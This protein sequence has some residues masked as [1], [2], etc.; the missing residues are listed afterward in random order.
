VREARGE[1]GIWQRRYWEH[2]I[3]DDGD[4][5][6]HVDYCYYNPV[7]H[8]LVERVRDWPFSTYHRDVRA[9]RF[10]EDWTLRAS[11]PEYSASDSRGRSEM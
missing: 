6:R 7:R 10:E 5:S 1:R 3:R 8:G 2:L 11:L 9:G 4:Y